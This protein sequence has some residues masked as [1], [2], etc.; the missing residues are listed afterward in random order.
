MPV[1][2]AATQGAKLRNADHNLQR[3]RTMS[4]LEGKVALVTGASKGIGA[5]IAKGLAAAG[6]SV[7]VNY[8]S[9]R[10]SAE[11]VVGSITAAG[12]R[13]IVVPGDVSKSADVARLFVETKAAY[14]ALLVLVNNADVYTH[15]ALVDMT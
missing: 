13:A 5:G 9:D 3:D 8:A 7:A 11:A 12:G 1:N 10:G 6:A 2:S 14:G 15:A 4:R